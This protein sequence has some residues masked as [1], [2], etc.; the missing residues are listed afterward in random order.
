MMAPGNFSKNH[1]SADGILLDPHHDTFNALGKAEN[2]KPKVIG[3]SDQNPRVL[4]ID[5]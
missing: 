1:R 2:L 3:L 4:S 5:L